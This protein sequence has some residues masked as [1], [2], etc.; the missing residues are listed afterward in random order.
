[1]SSD[2]LDT[3]TPTQALNTEP[4][5]SAKDE[6]IDIYIRL[7]GDSEKDYCFCLKRSSPVSALYK[8]F[9]YLPLVLSP[10]YFF[11]P[12]PRGFH[13][14]QSPGF[15]TS[16]GA[17]LFKHRDG[18][19][20]ALDETKT[21]AEVAREGQLFVPIF[22]KSYRRIFAVVGFL[23]LWL[24]TDLP[25]WASYTPGISLFALTS[26][27]YERWFPDGLNGTEPID[28]TD[29][30]YI[31]AHAQDGVIDVVFF[32]FHVIKV[33]VVFLIFFFGGFNP[34]S[35]NVVRTMFFREQRPDVTPEQLRD[36]GWTG[37]RRITPE[38]WREE[39]RNRKIEECGGA[40][41]AYE[42]GI[43]MGLTTAGIH[44]GPGEGFDTPRGWVP[45][46]T[47]ETD[48][49]VAVAPATTVA[50]DAADPAEEEDAPAAPAAPAEPVITDV[51]Q[52]M[53]RLGPDYEQQLSKARRAEIS[54]RMKVLGETVAVALKEW[55]RI[56]PL[57]TTQDVADRYILRKKF[58]DGP[59][60]LE[61]QDA[62]K[63]N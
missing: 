39:N 51:E 59:V 9:D 27:A 21:I 7:N 37:A 30:D 23:L 49:P 2:N 52:V 46:P 57:V 6:L 4:P 28:T 15:L 25:D 22:P 40:L 56:G 8:V 26:R 13:L 35:L 43:L 48:E 50:E 19:L 54:R 14:S 31:A 42:K 38:E 20:T 53:I 3:S 58:G 41:R 44:L 55:R 47:A 33:T 5:A 32:L 10:T 45:P 12:R 11:E 29:P 1:M 62:K 61:L 18:R 36:L 34:S 16:E 24:Y 60:R 63:T 17:L